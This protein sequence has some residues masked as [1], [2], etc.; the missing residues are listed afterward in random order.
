M[1]HGFSTSEQESWYDAPQKTGGRLVNEF[2]GF[3]RSPFNW[4]LAYSGAGCN[5]S[6]FFQYLGKSRCQLRKQTANDL[7]GIDSISQRQFWFLWY[8]NIR[9]L[10]AVSMSPYFQFPAPPGTQRSCH[11]L[12]KKN[13]GDFTTLTLDSLTPFFWEKMRSRLRSGV[14]VMVVPP[15]P[16]TWIRQLIRFQIYMWTWQRRRDMERPSH[17]YIVLSISS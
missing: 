11:I 15:F 4:S 16:L 8:G 1:H 17:E 13:G 14:R 2:F 6:M 10:L 3:C 5:Q 9:C 12:P 7:S